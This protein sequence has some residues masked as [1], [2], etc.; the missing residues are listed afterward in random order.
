MM[1]TPALPQPNA[2]RGEPASMSN[3]HQDVPTGYV[4]AGR[5]RKGTLIV[6]DGKHGPRI[7]TRREK[8]NST[9]CRVHYAIPGHRGAAN[10][11]MAPGYEYLRL[12]DLIELYLTEDSKT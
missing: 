2:E 1:T 9:H 11:D 7:V 4:L 6:L 8:W 3:E 12:D 5:I 10:M